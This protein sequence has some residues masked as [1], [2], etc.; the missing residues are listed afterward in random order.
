M[1]KIQL[2][3]PFLMIDGVFTA[4]ISGNSELLLKTFLADENSDEQI[5]PT[6]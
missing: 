3:W 4:I 5:M 1:P 6:L 2:L